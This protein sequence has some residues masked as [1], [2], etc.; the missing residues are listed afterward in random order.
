LAVQVG[1]AVA[2]PSRNRDLQRRYRRS[3]RTE[4]HPRR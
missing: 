3:R 2:G 1:F 4:I